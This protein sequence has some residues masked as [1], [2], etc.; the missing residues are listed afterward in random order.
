MH[1]RLNKFLSRAG[2]ASRRDAD[3]MIEQGMIRVNS[4]VVTQLGYKIDDE[5]DRVEVARR[6]VKKGEGLVYLMLNKPRGY[7]V[8]L[9][10][11]FSRPT[12]MKLLP[13]LKKRIFPVGR[14][15][16][17][18]EGLL[19]LTNDGELALRLTHPRYEVRKIYLVKVQGD[20]EPTKLGRLEKGIY[21]DRKKTAPARIERLYRSSKSTLLRVE[22]HEGRKRELRTMFRDIGHEVVRLK[23]IGFGGLK[24]GKLKRGEW[25]FLTSKEIEMLKRGSSYSFGAFSRSGSNDF[26]L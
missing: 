7:L 24:L 10:D 5:K 17:D 12:V 22:I 11:P 8:T 19:L 16:Y 20:P 13:R 2:I 23:R 9:K 1:I 3:R 15:D 4:K 25:R 18:S 26:Q 14:L 21:L 6:R